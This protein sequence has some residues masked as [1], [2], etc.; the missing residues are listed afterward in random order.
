MKIQLKNFGPIEFFEFDTKTQMHFIFGE[1]NIG[2]SYAISA[3]YLILKNFKQNIFPTAKLNNNDIRTF[4]LL[5]KSRS[6]GNE[7]VDVTKEFVEIFSLM[8]SRAF[9]P[10]IN[11]SFLTSFNSIESLTNQLTN[12]PLSIQLKGESAA[13]MI[14]INEE[15]VF[16]IKDVKFDFKILINQIN[17]NKPP[18]YFNKEKQLQLYFNKK[19]EMIDGLDASIDLFMREVFVDTIIEVGNVYFLP[20]SRSGLYN[21][22]SAFGAIF[23]EL[24][25]NRTS[26]R[27]KIELPTLTEPV[28]DYFLNLSSIR[29]GNKNGDSLTSIARQIEQ[30]VLK[31]EVLFNS[32]NKKLTYSPK[33]LN[34]NLDLSFTSSMISE[35]APIVAH[36]KYVIKETNKSDIFQSPS[37]LFIE[38]PEAHLHPKIQVELMKLFVNLSKSGVKVIVTSHS[39]YLFNKLSNLILAKEIDTDSVEVYHFKMGENGSYVDK[40]SMKI[41]VEGIEDANFSEIAE[42]LYAERLGLYENLE[43]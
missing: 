37:L 16:V 40:N 11:N 5:I 43:L 12:K 6:I 36:L 29:M 2:K 14:G 9:L 15:N 42:E 18:K 10:S 25:Q 33:N 41:D 30:S 8:F 31:G 21:A 34:L 22:L 19:L 23:A 28:S 17:T 32:E 7:S 38:E 3:V 20:A 39:N 4:E 24:S 26:I 1:N 13:F 35:I 27:S